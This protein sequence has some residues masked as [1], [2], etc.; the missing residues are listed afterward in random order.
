[1]EMAL[2]HGMETHLIGKVSLDSSSGFLLCST[3]G[4]FYMLG[5]W[6]LTPLSTIFRLYRG[7]QFYWWR[8]PEYLEKT[9][10]LPQVT[11]K[12]DHIM[13]YRTHNFSGDRHWLHRKLKTQPPYDHDHVLKSWLPDP[14][15]F[16]WTFTI[17]WHPSFIC[18][19]TFHILS[20]SSTTT[21]HLIFFGTKLYRNDVFVRY[22]RT[23]PL[24]SHFDSTKIMA[25]MENSCF[26]IDKTSFQ[27]PLSLKLKI[28][29]FVSW[30]KYCMWGPLYKFLI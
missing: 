16:M 17:S 14:K 24:W 1:M 27:C 28:K 3:P 25:A 12:L 9:T 21:G 11:D 6:C 7:G 5:L 29:W 8:K 4:T 30:H 13:L 19:L 15:R 22:P 2:N 20:I 23:V 18:S 26:W 10:D